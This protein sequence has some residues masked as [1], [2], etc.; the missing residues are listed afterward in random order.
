M[1]SE[2]GPCEGIDSAAS[3]LFIVATGFAPVTMMDCF[4]R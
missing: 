4:P 2:D 3:I 1:P